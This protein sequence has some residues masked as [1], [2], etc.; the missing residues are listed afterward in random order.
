M[1]NIKARYSCPPAAPIT[2]TAFRGWNRERLCSCSTMPIKMSARSILPIM[3]NK[4]PGQRVSRRSWPGEIGSLPARRVSGAGLRHQ[5]GA[6]LTDRGYF[7]VSEGEAKVFLFD[8]QQARPISELGLSRWFGENAPLLLDAAYR[9]ANGHP[10]P[11]ADNP[12]NPLGTGYA[13]GHDRLLDRLLVTKRDFALDSGLASPGS[14][15]H[16]CG[17]GP[18]HFPNYHGIIAQRES[19]GWRYEGFEGCRM[20]F[21]KRTTMLVREERTVESIIP[22]DADIH[23][24]LD[25]SGSFSTSGL[26]NIRDAV[27][28]WLLSFGMDNPNWSGT[29]LFHNREDERWLGWPKRVHDWYLGKGADPATKSVIFLSFCN[30]SHDV[31]HANY[32]DSV[33]SISQPTAAFMEDY[34]AFMQVYPKFKSFAGIL[35][36]IVYTGSGQTYRANLLHSIAAMHGV[37]MT[38]Q[39]AVTELANRNMAFSEGQWGA[40]KQSL[41][42]ANPYPDGGLK[43]FNW[44]GK[45]DRHSDGG[46]DVI[47]AVQFNTDIS[48]LLASIPSVVTEDVE[49]LK[50]T[51]L[52]GYVDGT[53]VDGGVSHDASWTLSWQMGN[54]AAR[55]GWA[56][57]H[58]YLPGMYIGRENGMLS[59]PVPPRNGQVF[60]K[61][62]KKGY[63]HNFYG[64][65]FPH[66][67]ELVS[68]PMDAQVG[69]W[70]GL[71]LMAE[72]R[73]ESGGDWHEVRLE[74]HNKMVAYNHRQCSGLVP[75]V[76]KDLRGLPEDYLMSQ[77]KDGHFVPADRN[78]LD[79]SL[80]NLRDIR[81]DYGSPIWDS[82]LAARQAGYWRDAALNAASLDKGKDWTQME[83][84]R[85]RYLVVRLVYDRPNPIR[86]LTWGLA[87][88]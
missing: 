73:L 7:F 41:M 42:T 77:A 64:R 40:M 53:P 81:T 44:R 38:A 67:I 59:A 28:E 4:P 68:L 16:I 74:I 82:S 1:A 84:F 43:N 32:H 50:D 48:E 39:E 22:S 15:L 18:V 36:P 8:G 75:I 17:D 78:E 27:D 47:D 34:N 72:G 63:Y 14:A 86:L 12:A 54:A 51:T 71:A 80:H 57:W 10:Y 55:E 88:Q 5:W 19:D 58:S 62:G 35:Y 69:I 56:S 3:K 46:A 70:D 26:Q 76:P 85:G 21:S 23:V 52:Y 79:W 45:W 30:E 20:K 83:P 6:L 66:E 13:L 60:W 37:P 25:T 49:V 29:R 33:F 65:Q 11:F 24:F 87:K 2:S 31:Y 61:H 9:K